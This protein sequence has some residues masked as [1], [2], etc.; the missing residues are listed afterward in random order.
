MGPGK[1]DDSG[2]HIPVT[3]KKG[4]FVLIPEYGG[5]KV[6][7]SEQE[8]LYLYREDD[9]LAVLEEAV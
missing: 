5:T 4:D 1:R 9:I 6:T 2:K 8:E 3:L 7:L